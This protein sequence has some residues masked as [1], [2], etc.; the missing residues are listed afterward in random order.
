MRF[1]H[2]THN[3]V[4]MQWLKLSDFVLSITSI[5][6]NGILSITLNFIYV[7]SL[8]LCAHDWLKTRPKISKVIH[9]FW[10]P[11]DVLHLRRR[12]NGTKTRNRRFYDFFS[13]CIQS[14]VSITYCEEGVFETCLRAQWCASVSLWAPAPAPETKACQ[15][16]RRREKKRKER[17]DYLIRKLSTVLFRSALC[18]PV[19][20]LMAQEESRSGWLLAFLLRTERQGTFISWYLLY[21]TR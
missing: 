2:F 19:P 14:Q 13:S 11:R 15:R 3:W 12:I 5:S 10:R 6:L 20:R 4:E 21:F 1:D 9:L 8:F 16:L 18:P 7:V 17:R